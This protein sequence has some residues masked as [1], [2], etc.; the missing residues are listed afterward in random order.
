MPRAEKSS[1]E[2]GERQLRSRTRDLQNVGDALSKGQMDIQLVQ[3]LKT[4]KSKQECEEIIREAL[5]KDLTLE[6]PDKQSLAM[7]ADLKMSWFRLNKLRRYLV[8]VL[9]LININ[10]IYHTF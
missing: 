7:K 5:G 3:Y 8:H 10:P 2:V 9:I 4:K 6:I 1:D